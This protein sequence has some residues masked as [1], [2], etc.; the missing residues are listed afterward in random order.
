MADRRDD[1]VV[2]DQAY[3]E[4]LASR[5]L[6][7]ESEADTFVRDDAA[8]G[9]DA[10]LLLG[11][12]KDFASN[13]AA[14]VDSLDPDVDSSCA[15][16]VVAVQR[17]HSHHLI[18]SSFAVDAAADVVSSF[19]FRVKVPVVAASSDSLVV[20]DASVPSNL[21]PFGRTAA[22]PFV[23]LCAVAESEV[24]GHCA[25]RMV[26][27]VAMVAVDPTNL[28]CLATSSCDHCSM[29]AR[30]TI[31]MVLYQRHSCSDL[32]LTIRCPLDFCFQPND[33][34]I[35]SVLV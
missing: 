6:V 12:H 11:V 10:V 28:H 8:G 27:V 21:D 22:R 1:A 14:L 16:V 3:L 31:T 9:V 17:K 35:A 24:V 19:V 32:A 33:S 13:R 20:E 26:V 7:V 34:Q 2:V 30:I 5:M 15:E 29:S 4:N 25:Y 23:V 18:S